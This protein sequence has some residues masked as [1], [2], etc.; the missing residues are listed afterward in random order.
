MVDNQNRINSILTN[1]FNAVISNKYVLGEPCN[2]FDFVY[3]SSNGLR[4]AQGNSESTVP[5]IGMCME[6]AISGE[7]M[8]MEYG[9]AVNTAWNL[10]KRKLIYLSQN[11]AG[12]F[13]QKEFV[14]F[15]E[16]DVLQQ[17]GHP[18]S[19]KEMVVH[20]NTTFVVVGD[21]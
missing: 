14:D 8:V 11:V 4:K 20:P 17:L 19:E 7:V 13:N 9:V 10:D 1:S 21:E 6:S 5:A 16:D 2:A 18:K 12:G 15:V 3:M